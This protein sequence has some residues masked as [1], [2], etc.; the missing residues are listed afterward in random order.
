MHLLLDY[1]K[2]NNRLYRLTTLKGAEKK[3][4]CTEKRITPVPVQYYR[5]VV[6]KVSKPSDIST[7]D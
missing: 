7:F 4:S 3:P 1:Y 5:T 2:N 6:D